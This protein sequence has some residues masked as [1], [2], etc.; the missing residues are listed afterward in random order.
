MKAKSE[1]FDCFRKYHVHPE[2]HTGA[3]IRS[4]NVTKR[5]RK[6]AEEPKALRT[7]NGGQYLSNTLNRAFKSTGYN[8]NSR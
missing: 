4:V 8:S 3:K 5:T 7:D 2:R 1:T 6:T